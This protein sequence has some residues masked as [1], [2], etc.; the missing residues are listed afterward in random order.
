MSQLYDESIWKYKTSNLNN[1]M[2]TKNKKSKRGVKT[3]YGNYAQVQVPSPFG[4]PTKFKLHKGRK[5]LIAQGASKKTFMVNNSNL[6]DS[7][8]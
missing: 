8:K 7:F 3:S 5:S 4:C 6:L 2:T 1:S